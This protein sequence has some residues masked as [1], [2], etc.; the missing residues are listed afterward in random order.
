[1]AIAA[2]GRRSQELRLEYDVSLRSIEQRHALQA[3]FDEP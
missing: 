2:D 3:Q 1:V